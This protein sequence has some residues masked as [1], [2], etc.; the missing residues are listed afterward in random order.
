MM[1]CKATKYDRRR[2]FQEEWLFTQMSKSKT[3]EELSDKLGWDGKIIRI[4]TEG[5]RGG[6]CGPAPLV[7]FNNREGQIIINSGLKGKD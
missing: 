4:N 3:E 1:P 2:V 6:K 5:G 7:V